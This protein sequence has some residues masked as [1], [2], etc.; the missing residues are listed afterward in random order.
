ME[1]HAGF[2]FRPI[3]GDNPPRPLCV[4]PTVGWRIFR[5][6]F[7]PYNCYEKVAGAGLPG[8]HKT[9]WKKRRDG[10]PVPYTS[11]LNGA[12]TS[13]GAACLRQPK[14]VARC[15]SR[16]N[17]R[18]LSLYRQKTTVPSRCR[19][20]QRLMRPDK[21]C[22][23]ASRRQTSLTTNCG[24]PFFT[25]KTGLSPPETQLVCASR[26]LSRDTTAAAT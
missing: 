22:T 21:G 25:A 2:L 19:V 10:K 20:S 3:A 5:F 7:L 6:Y 12:D 1:N 17:V 11:I 24:V 4:Y 15:N 14:P 9:F 13:R 26:S 18:F 8:P 16:I 23:A